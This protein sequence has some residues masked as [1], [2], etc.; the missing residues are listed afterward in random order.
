M[1]EKFKCYNSGLRSKKKDY[2]T[3]NCRIESPEK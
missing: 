1:V 3:I 2:P